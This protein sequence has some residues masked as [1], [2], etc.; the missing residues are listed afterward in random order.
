MT[1][2]IGELF[3]KTKRLNK[4]A[5]DF[6]DHEDTFQVRMYTHIILCVLMGLYYDKEH[7][8]SGQHFMAF[9]FLTKKNK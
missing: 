2:T 8:Q 3:D 5:Y 6:Y 1:L 4:V 9:F 7:I